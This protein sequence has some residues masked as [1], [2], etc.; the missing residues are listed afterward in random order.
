MDRQP[1]SAFSVRR[2]R[3]T[4]VDAVAHIEQASY[5][6]PWQAHLFDD[7]LRARYRCFVAVDT[8]GQ[9]RGYAL[10]SVV[11]DE[12][13]VLNLCV[14]P[15]WRRRGI[16]RL[17]LDCM[18]A[19]AAAAQARNMLLEVRPSNRGARK[20]YAA[21]GFTRIG[22]RP[23]YYPA[24]GGREDAHLLSRRIVAARP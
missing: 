5:E 13:H 17:L 8:V 12:A 3:A 6:F 23:R 9:V 7:C 16:A 20:L 4:D 10:L 19:E 22:M 21:Y 24:A 11:L 14:A 2:M 1:Q 18:L 15:A